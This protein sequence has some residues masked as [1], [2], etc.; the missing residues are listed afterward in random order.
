MKDGL[1]NQLDYWPL[2]G[3]VE[4]QLSDTFPFKVATPAFAF[5]TATEDT[6]VKVWCRSVGVG[7]FQDIAIFPINLEFFPAG[8]TDFEFYVEALT[9]I[10][11]L[12]RVPIT[13]VAAE[14]EPAG[15]VV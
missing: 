5:L 6:R 14:S 10:M 7:L 3:L 8:D 2:S 12:E 13:A 1:G 11:G 4:G 15:W 9:P